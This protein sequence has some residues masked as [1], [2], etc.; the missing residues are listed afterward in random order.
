MTL[1]QL[2]AAAWATAEDYRRSKSA[3]PD[4]R[5][6]ADTLRDLV[7]GFSASIPADTQERLIRRLTYQLDAACGANGLPRRDLRKVHEAA[8]KVVREYHEDAARWDAIRRQR[9]AQ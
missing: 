1:S 3:R 7:H 6:I 2:A 5:E 4:G 8:A 9:A